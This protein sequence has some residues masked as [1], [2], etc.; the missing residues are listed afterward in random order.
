M[1]SYERNQTWSLKFASENLEIDYYIGQRHPRVLPE[2]FS[3]T[4]IVLDELK[5]EVISINEAVR[6][7]VSLHHPTPYPFNTKCEGAQK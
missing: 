7:M 5:T 4:S 1:Q 6:P 2:F 3:E